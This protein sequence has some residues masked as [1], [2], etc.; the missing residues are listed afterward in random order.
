MSLAGIFGW[1][2]DFALDIRRG[3]HFEVLFEDNLL[4]EK[5]LAAVILL[6]PYLPTKDPLLKPSTIPKMVT[7]TMKMAEQ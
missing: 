3:D 1:D 6:P 4:K 5:I 2:I 7:I